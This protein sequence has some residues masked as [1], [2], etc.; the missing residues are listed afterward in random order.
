MLE[1]ESSLEAVTALKNDLMA[2][3]ISIQKQ[4]ISL[5][6]IHA[7][8]ASFESPF[9]SV[10]QP[11]ELRDSGALLELKRKLIK[12]TDLLDK[13]GQLTTELLSIQPDGKS[14][15]EKQKQLFELGSFQKTITMLKDELLSESLSAQQQLITLLETQSISPTSSNYSLHLSDESRIFVT[16]EA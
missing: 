5:T 12:C 9:S 14:L 7:S 6:D 13:L 2:E 16:F 4:L 8:S 1:L 10:D 15:R 11:C 3:S